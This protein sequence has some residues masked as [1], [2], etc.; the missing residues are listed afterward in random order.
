MNQERIHES[1]YRAEGVRIVGDVTIKEGSSVWYNAVIRGDTNSITVGKGTNIQ[2]GAIFHVDKNHPLTV[3]NGVSVGHGAI[4][5]G[6]T[7]GDHTLVGMG[8]I[9]LSGAQVGRGCIIGA[10]AVVTGKQ[11]IPDGML[12]LG[13]PSRII[14]PLTGAEKQEIR[15]NTGRYEKLARE[16]KE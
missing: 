13:N 14:R 1:V 7:V 9:V 16:A 2:D 3:G 5:H 10:G 11:V 15:D 12:V 4:L 8:A 6:C